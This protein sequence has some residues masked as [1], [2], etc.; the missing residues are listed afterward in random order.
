MEQFRGRLEIPQLRVNV[1]QI[2]HSRAGLPGH[3]Q[4]LK[5][6]DR[7]L[8]KLQCICIIPALAVQHSQGAKNKGPLR[9]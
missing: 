9:I 6:I 8:P 2:A 3:L 5:H 4:L 7:I 1:R